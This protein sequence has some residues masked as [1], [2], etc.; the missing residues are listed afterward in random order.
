MERAAAYSQAW[1]DCLFVPALENVDLDLLS[2]ICAASPLPVNAMHLG[3]P[4]GVAALAAVGVTRVSH[5]SIPFRNATTW[6]TTPTTGATTLQRIFVTSPSYILHDDVYR[7]SG[8][9][10]LALIRYHDN[11]SLYI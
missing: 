8:T 1:A 4:S 7:R 6:D 10:Q 11:I 5:G 2:T 9:K 3:P